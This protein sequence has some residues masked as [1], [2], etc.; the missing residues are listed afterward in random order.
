MKTSPLA[1]HLPILLSLAAFGCGGAISEPTPIETSSG[2]EVSATATTVAVT[3]VDVAMGA[4]DADPPH[5]RVAML[6]TDDMGRSSRVELGEYVGNCAATELTPPDLATHQC[7]WAGQGQQFHVRT[8]TGAILVFKEELDEATDPDP[9]AA[10]EIRRVD[11]P[12]AAT[13]SAP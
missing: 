4:P 10:R 7:W 9:S 13:V 2:G 6:L 1:P 12:A 11:V 5:T 3:F 8:S